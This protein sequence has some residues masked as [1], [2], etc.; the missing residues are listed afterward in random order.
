[1]ASPARPGPPLRRAGRCFLVFLLYQKGRDSRIFQAPATA[2]RLRHRHRLSRRIAA[3][4]RAGRVAAG[5][6]AERGSFRI[7][8]PARGG[9]EE[10]A[11][12]AAKAG[13]RAGQPRIRASAGRKGRIADAISRPRRLAK[14]IGRDRRPRRMQ[15][16][17]SNSDPLLLSLHSRLDHLD[18]AK[19]AFGSHR[20]LENLGTE[21]SLGGVAPHLMVTDPPYGVNYDP[22]WRNQVG[23][24]INGTTQRIGTGTVIK[25]IGARAVGKVVNDD[26]ADWREAWAL[27]PGSVAYIWHAGTKAGIVQDS[28][29]ACGFETPSQIIWAKNNFA[30]GRGHYHCKHEPCWYVVRKGSTASWVGDHSQTTLWQIDKNLKYET[31]HGTQKPVE[32]M[33]RPIENNASPGQAVYE[34]F[35]G[36][37]TTIIAAEMTGRVCHAIEIAPAYVDVAVKRWQEFTGQQ[38]VLDGDGRSFDNVAAQRAR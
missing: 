1:M 28:L 30:I 5:T 27:F 37:G 24:S 33:R 18:K 29:A 19:Q 32:C 35:S 36:S 26:Q 10:T 16:C 22:A 3:A 2:D 31:G 21:R 13:V 8:A 4:R 15:P 25:P 14:L 23:R 20:Q 34:P 12:R 9:I 17:P 6:A 11:A 7:Y 38:A